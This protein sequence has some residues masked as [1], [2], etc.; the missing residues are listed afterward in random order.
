MSNL[1]TLKNAKL[2]DSTR[3][4]MGLSSSSNNFAMN[5]SFFGIKTSGGLLSAKT[6]GMTTSRS[7]MNLVDASNDDINS[8]AA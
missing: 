4:A 2:V 1:F 8:K 6:L 5:R 3:T 7:E